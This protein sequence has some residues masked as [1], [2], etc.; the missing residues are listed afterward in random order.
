MGETFG[1]SFHSL[2]RLL[3]LRTSGLDPAW[4]ALALG[5]CE[6]VRHA[7]G[8]A[9]HRYRYVPEFRPSEATFVVNWSFR[10]SIFA[11]L[12]LL[13]DALGKR[14]AKRLHTKLTAPPES[15]TGSSTANY[16]QQF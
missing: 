11:L 3:E 1:H 2:T 12:G 15:S 10:V 4:S 16:A 5:C 13:R 8:E 7:V 14:P 9:A 6:A